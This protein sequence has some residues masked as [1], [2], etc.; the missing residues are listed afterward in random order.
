[1]MKKLICV[2]LILFLAGCTV[3]PK[4]EADPN[5]SYLDMIDLIN[6]YDSFGT[7]SNHFDI[8][9]E[10]AKIDSG[11]RF[12]VYIDNARVAMYDVEVMAIEKGVDYRK[13]MAANLG[14]FDSNTYNLVPNQANPAKGYYEGIVV[15]G[16]SQNSACELYILVQ[17]KNRE[18]S[19]YYREYFMLETAFSGE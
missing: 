4:Q 11:Y 17:W 12:Y 9:A 8:S 16:V 6:E 13:Q 5:A 19:K 18:L 2:L 3:D 7:V 1:M 15:S 14:I 10:L